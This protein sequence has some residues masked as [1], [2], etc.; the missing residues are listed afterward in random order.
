MSNQMVTSEIR[1]QFQEPNSVQ[2]IIISRDQAPPPPCPRLLPISLNFIGDN[3]YAFFRILLGVILRV[4][5]FSKES[6]N[7]LTYSFITF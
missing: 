3:Y 1:E 7:A 4:F 2:I 5:R 6:F